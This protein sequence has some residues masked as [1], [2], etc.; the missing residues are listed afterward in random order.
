VKPGEPAPD[1]S[2][3]TSRGDTFSLSAHRGRVVVLFFFPAAF[4][5]GCTR[6]AKGF[7]QAWQDFA[8][9]GA[10]VIGI[11][12]DPLEKQC[13]FANELHLPYRLMADTDSKISEAYGSVWPLLGRTR[14]ATFVIGPDGVVRNVFRHELRPGEHV[15]EA[16]DAT[17]LA[18][19]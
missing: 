12:P 10:E 1:F 3:P 8:D 6:E 17:R 15:S 13:R 18:R 9:M 4:T 19:T 16:K 14:R 7:A 11:S 2:G 5:P